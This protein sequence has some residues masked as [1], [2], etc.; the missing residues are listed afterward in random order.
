MNLDG[1]HSP[2]QTRQA[3]FALAEFVRYLNLAT[4]DD[5]PGLERPSDV[6]DLI[7][8][9]KT[10]FE[11]MPQLLDQTGAWL[12]RLRGNPALGDR[13]AGTVAGHAATARGAVGET[14]ELLA[15]VAQGVEDARELLRQAHNATGGLYLE[16]DSDG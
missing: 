7:G 6:H 14:I 16:D 10:A 2:E 5:A 1:S 12:E 3:A 15:E 9:L 13:Y 8:A 11:R 4:R